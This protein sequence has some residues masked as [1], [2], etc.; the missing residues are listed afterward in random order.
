M[1]VVGECFL[2]KLNQEDLRVFGDFKT[3]KE[4]L[5]SCNYD[6]DEIDVLDM[7][8]CYNDLTIEKLPFEMEYR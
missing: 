4:F 3:L 7:E 1:K 8:G 6:E 5:K 2:L